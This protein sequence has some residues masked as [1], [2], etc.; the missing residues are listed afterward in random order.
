MGADILY[1]RQ[2]NMG[3]PSARIKGIAVSKGDLIAFLDADDAWPHDHLELLS[4]PFNRF[5]NT[6]IVSGRGRAFREESWIEATQPSPARPE[7]NMMSFGCSLIAR[8]VFD[9]IGPIDTALPHGCDLDWFLRCRE[10]G[11][12]IVVLE[13]VVLLYRR[14]SDNMTN[15]PKNGREGLMR[16]ARTALNRRRMADCN[17]RL[18]NWQTLAPIPPDGEQ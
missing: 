11:I 1:V 13:A 15:D 18:A 9:K 12:A 8:T 17:A 7:G 2:D 5:P 10:R 14:H 3:E 4:N 16:V 6:E